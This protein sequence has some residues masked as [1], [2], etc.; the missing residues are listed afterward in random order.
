MAWSWHCSISEVQNREWIWLKPIRDW[1]IGEELAG[2][3]IEKAVHSSRGAC[4]CS[5]QALIAGRIV[6]GRDALR[7][8]RHERDIGNERE[9][10]G[11][12]TKAQ[13]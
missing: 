10:N 2:I 3:V 4:D 1:S 6:D 9:L 7:E 8:A 13:E 11:C 12:R 5:T